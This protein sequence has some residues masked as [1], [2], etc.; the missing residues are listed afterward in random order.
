M[1]QGSHVVCEPL[2]DFSP[3]VY[4]DAESRLSALN[5]LTTGTNQNKQTSLAVVALKSS[6]FIEIQIRSSSISAEKYLWSHEGSLT[7]ILV[8]FLRYL[9]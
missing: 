2:T 7:K 8:E 9:G 4:F 5:H 6:P 3:C 1:A